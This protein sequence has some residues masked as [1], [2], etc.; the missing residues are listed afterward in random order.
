MPRNRR[1]WQ[2]ALG[3][4]LLCLPGALA[5]QPAIEG[6]PGRPAVPADP[7]QDA[8]IATANPLASEA[9][10]EV[11]AGGGSAIDAMIAAQLVLNL[12][13]PQSS[14]I[15]GGAFLLYWDAQARELVTLDGRE[16]AP[17]MAGPDYFLD[18]D[19]EPLGFWDAVVGGRSVGVPGTLRLL[20]EAHGRWGTMKWADLLQPA[21]DLAEG[22]FE[23]SPRL[24]EAIAEAQER[25]L[26]RFPASERYFF[27]ETGAPKAAGTILRNPEF[28]R[29]LGII[30]ENGAD[31]FYEGPIAE[32]I[33]NLVRRTGAL[34]G[35]VT[36]EDL[37]AYEAKVREPVCR[38]YRAWRVCGMGPPSSGGIAVL[39]ILGLLEHLDMPGLGPSVDGIHA[40]LEAM[41]L[42][43][44]DRNAYVADEDFV[45]VP[46]EGL[47]DDA[48]LTARAQLLNLD[49]A[50]QTPVAA[51]NPPW[52]DAA[53]RA[54][55]PTVERPGTS[56]LVIVDE[57]GN[58]V[59]MTTTIESGFGSR[60]MTG[61]F[62]LNNEL[63]DFSFR[64]EVDGRPVANR[65]EGGKRPRSSMA[66]TIVF[67]AEGRPVLLVGSPG[68]SRIIGY[69]A[70]TIV[71]HLDWG[72]P[73]QEAIDF[74]NVINL[75]GTSELEA[76]TAVAAFA[77][78]LEAR[79][80]TIELRP[81]VSGVQAIRIDQ[82]RLVGGAD[83]R[84][85]GLA[86]GR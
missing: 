62:L 39:Q 83:P 58:A 11:L 84:R 2:S 45:Q 80:H 6:A 36:T 64:P 59:S 57:R 77:P 65:V 29:T 63:T 17:A 24:A 44:A 55:D 61:G 50:L 34:P 31:S 53:S 18:A 78:L 66:P 13:E 74:A 86:L 26:A 69:V 5:D 7:P 10:L 75:N 79:G 67:D 20:E 12:A 38:P 3:A 37:A 25:G 47:L 60:L 33:V 21:I 16:T 40:I 46:T 70:K 15:G 72:L 43:F 32:G 41:K 68:G 81:Q 35:A 14:G 42:A 82:G 4:C 51:G 56:H 52:R 19:G 48:Y 30:A 54:P 28:A 76:D 9:G 27:D 71:A 23:I 73:L 8:M 85:E 49:R 22:G 1:V